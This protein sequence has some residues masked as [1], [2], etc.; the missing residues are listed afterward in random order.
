MLN[1]PIHI[2]AAEFNRVE[3]ILQGAGPDPAYLPGSDILSG[4]LECLEGSGYFRVKNNEVDNLTYIHKIYF[5]IYDSTGTN[6]HE[7][8]HRITSLKDRFVISN[9]NGTDP[10]YIQFVN[11]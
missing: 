3:A 10:R 7:S 5:T 1:N 8:S 6:I 11:A 2:P 9:R 4:E